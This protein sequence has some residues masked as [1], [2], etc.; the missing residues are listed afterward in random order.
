MSEATDVLTIIVSEETGQISVARHG[1]VSSNLSGKELRNEI[2]QY[3]FE[4][5]EGPTT[6]FDNSDMESTVTEK[7]VAD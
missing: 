4:E 2:F 1:Q 3:L 5:K 6:I 7:T